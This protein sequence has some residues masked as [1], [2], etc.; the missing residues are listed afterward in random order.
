MRRSLKFLLP[1]ALSLAVSSCAEQSAKQT[2][3][4]AKSYKTMT[5]ALGASDV[6][7]LYSASIRAAE[8]VEVRPQISGIITEILLKEGAEVKKG[9]SLFI[10]DQTSYKA[11]LEVAEASV[12]S[13]ESAVATA[14]LNA[15][16]G[17]ELL[18]ESIISENE[19]MVT[20]NTLAAAEAALA[21]AIAQRDI[22]ADNLAYTDIKS[23]VDGI[24]G[25]INYRTGALVSSSS[26]E[27]LVNVSDNSCMHIYFSMSESQIL[28]L[29]R[30]SGSTKQLIKDMPKVALMLNDGTEYKHLG[31]IDAISGT[32]EQSTGSVAMRATFANPEQMLR[33]GGNGRIKITNTYSNVITIPKVATFDIQDK[34][35]AYRVIDGKASSTE[36]TV[37]PIDNGREYIVLSGLKAGDTIVAEGAGLVREGAQIEANK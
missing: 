12:K 10:I 18:G 33:D 24:A 3:R 13:A 37:M 28:S 35:F 23:P 31:T 11:A 19:Y 9:E 2:T 20:K 16:S 8:F 32:I 4:A 36:I 29:I 6:S 1:L 5:I 25:M 26:S 34:I 30:Q 22:A 14:K 15:T 21:L 27:A 7:R 17:Q